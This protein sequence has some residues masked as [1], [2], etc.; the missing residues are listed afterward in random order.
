M[1]FLEFT[2][3][4]FLPYLGLGKL[5]EELH[6]NEGQCIWYDTF[7]VQNTMLLRLVNDI[8]TTMNSDNMLC[9]CFDYI[10]VM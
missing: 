6:T 9:G 3:V 4:S 10:Q 7:Q 8:V 5:C 2:D 1:D